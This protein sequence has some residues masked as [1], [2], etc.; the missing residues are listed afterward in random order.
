MNFI[1]TQD[2]D[3]ANLLRANGFTELAKEGSLF[4]F[5]NQPGKMNFSESDMKKL[6]FT[7]KICV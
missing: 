7:N 6:I 2:T 4:V 1:K 5:I 3:T